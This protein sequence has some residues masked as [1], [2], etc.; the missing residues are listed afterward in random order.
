MIPP[1]GAQVKPLRRRSK[2][3]Q[4]RREDINKDPGGEDEKE[5]GLPHW[6]EPSN[7]KIRFKK[8]A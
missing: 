4:K 2:W 7:S 1:I 5:H 3:Q 8:H 6:V